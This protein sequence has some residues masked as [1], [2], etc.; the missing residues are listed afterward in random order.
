MTCPNSHLEQFWKGAKHCFYCGVLLLTTI[1][2][3]QTSPPKQPA[4]I[5]Y[6]YPTASANI[7]TSP[8]TVTWTNGADHKP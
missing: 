5:L 3:G 7:N 8:V 1:A 2:P 6:V 4:P